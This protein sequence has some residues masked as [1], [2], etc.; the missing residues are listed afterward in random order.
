MRTI[1]TEEEFCLQKLKILVEIFFK[2]LDIRFGCFSFS[3]LVVRSKEI[4]IGAQFL[5]ERERERVIRKSQPEAIS[6]NCAS[7]LSRCLL[8]LAFDLFSSLLRITGRTV[9]ALPPHVHCSATHGAAAFHNLS[10]VM[11][12]RVAPVTLGQRELRHGL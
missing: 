7:A 5:R 2:L 1:R 9:V 3:G 10:A 11:E 4:P 6:T 8:S 12:R